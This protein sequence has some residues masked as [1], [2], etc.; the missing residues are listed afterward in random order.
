MVEEYCPTKILMGLPVD[1]ELSTAVDGEQMMGVARG[2]REAPGVRA[3]RM[4]RV[5]QFRGSC[6]LDSKDSDPHCLGGGCLSAPHVRVL[7]RG[8][9]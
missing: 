5:L 6:P 4:T 8:I 1:V 9:P 3:A 7:S 2:A